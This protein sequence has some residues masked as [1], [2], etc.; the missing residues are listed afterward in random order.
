L[1]DSLVKIVASLKPMV[2]AVIALGAAFAEMVAQV[3]ELATGLLDAFGPALVAV[4]GGLAETFK[5]LAGAAAMLKPVL[6]IVGLL[7]GE[8]SF[9][10]GAIARQCERLM[11]M[12]VGIKA[13]TSAFSLM[14]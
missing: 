13:A 5:V 12:T 10:V 6:L 8:D 14:R 1:R 2:P 11:K 7:L 9:I 3:A 4:F